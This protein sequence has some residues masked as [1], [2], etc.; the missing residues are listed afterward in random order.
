MSG[1]VPVSQQP[2]PS[3]S[4]T[5]MWPK[6]GEWYWITDK[7]DGEVL[8]CCNHLGSNHAQ[9]GVHSGKYQYTSTV[10]D[11]DMHTILHEPDWQAILQSRVTEAQHKLTQ[12]IRSLADHCKHNKLLALEGERQKP[13]AL[14]VPTDLAKQ[15]TDLLKLRDE[16]LPA[17]NE[18]IDALMKDIVGNY[19][20]FTLPQRVMADTLMDAAN[21]V[22]D[23]LFALELYA[24]FEEQVKMIGKGKPAPE[25]TPITIR[26][27]LRYMDEETLI[28]AEDGG[29]D[30]KKL[31]DFDKWAVTNMESVL[32]E[33]RCI[34]AFKIRRFRKD[35]GPCGSI[36][37]A[38]RHIEWHQANEW[39]YLLIRNGRQVFRIATDLDFAPRLLPFR[40]E[41]HKPLIK[42]AVWSDDEDRVIT[43]AD[44]EY[45]AAMDQRE[46]DM[47]H[48]NR[49]IFIIQGLLD[50][51]KVFYP[52][53]PISLINADDAA[54]W[55]R[56]NYDEEDGLPSANPPQWEEY[57]ARLNAQIKP[58]TIVWA[59]WEGEYRWREKYTPRFA[60]YFKVE[61]VSRDRQKV[62]ISQPWQDRWG[63]TER[64]GW[65]FPRKPVGLRGRWGR[66][67]VTRRKHYTVEISRMVN[68][69]AYKVGDYKQFLCDAYTKGAYLQWA[70]FLLKAER[71]HKMTDEEKA[72]I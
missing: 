9:F 34:V 27:M 38:L 65:E 21:G 4:S 43:T 3:R 39:T 28:S 58:G 26:Q 13:G 33:L 47:K 70:P 54:K 10:M 45:D 46:K 1:I 67:P 23:R 56:P 62:N 35:Y 64:H 61:S 32:P 31:A 60:D 14:V 69:E 63:D 19:T 15:K 5:S 49:M 68:V 57:Q 30:F 29:M 36:S 16:V 42:K 8:M 24:G 48:Y 41:F 52:H 7:E 2:E 51:T 17:T 22:S 12:A 59:T 71:F 18:E 20:N 53:P 44:Y 25:D 11:T 55:I 66:W 6:L 37:Q 72:A 40:E 50:R